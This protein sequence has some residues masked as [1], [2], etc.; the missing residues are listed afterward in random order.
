MANENDDREKI[1]AES[2][3]T[4][5][6]LKN[7]SKLDLVALDSFLSAVFDSSLGKDIEGINKLVKMVSYD[8]TLHLSLS[9][10][11]DNPDSLTL[12]VWVEPSKDQVVS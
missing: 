3:F 10:I 2:V 12:K 11:R 5:R 6:D 9:G 7:V 4:K 8:T 1:V